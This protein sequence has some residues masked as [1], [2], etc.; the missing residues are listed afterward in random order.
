MRSAIRL[1]AVLA[2]ALTTLA[3]ALPAAAAPVTVNVGAALTLTGANDVYGLSSRRG[4]DMAAAEINAGAIK[5]V[6]V[7]VKAIDD[8]GTVPGA[9]AAYGIFLR[10]R[11]SVIMGPTLSSVALTVDN[12]AQ[13]GRTPVVA[14]SNTLP[15]ITE[16][17]DYIFRASLTEQV[18]LPAVVKAVASSPRIQPKT[19]V[20][21]QGSDTF[22]VDTA[23]I[24]ASAIT[25]NGMT[26]TKTVVVP[27]FTTDFSAIAAEVKA[28]D[29]DIVAMTALPAEGIPLL[30]ALRG[31]GYRKK[32]IGSN[33]FNTQDV[34]TGA[35]TA[36]NGVIVG[37]G[38]SSASTTT[39][40]V[41]WI[42]AFRK[43]YKRT[44]DQFA[45]TAYAATYVVAQAAAN[46]KTAT[47]DGLRTQLA[48]ITGSKR[49]PTLLG[50]FTF[51]ANRNGISPVVVQEIVDGSFTLFEAAK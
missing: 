22:A 35:G 38:W 37:A 5:G 21:V 7:N 9:S 27:P 25:A 51:D 47:P 36:S 40:N 43:L 12:F 8:L 20:I 18:V 19:A 2:A 26:L 28:A 11:V 30:K 15:G 1:A 48:A 16:I 14:V 46:G 39:R 10:D 33:A 42:K 23:P 31:A 49:V 13:G 50:R 24:F 6:K 32:I 45:A 41:N 3:L 17:G 44:P 29:P 34:I 4:I